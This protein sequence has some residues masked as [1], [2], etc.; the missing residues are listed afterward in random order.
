MK[1]VLIRVEG[2]VQAVCFRQYALSKAKQVGLTGYVTN[3][4]D[5]SVS[6]LAQ[7]A[8]SPVDSLIDWCHIGSPQ[9][10]VTRV[11]VEEDEANEIYLDFSIVQS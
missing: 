3:N 1:R 7:G 8:S 9:A 2:K 11:Q 5:G 6:L 10:Q 4:D